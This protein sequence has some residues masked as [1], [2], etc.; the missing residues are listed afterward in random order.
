MYYL[1]IEFPFA[2]KEHLRFAFQAISK[3]HILTFDF[4]SPFTKV[5]EFAITYLRAVMSGIEVGIILAIVGVICAAPEALHSVT[6]GIMRL[7]G[8]FSQRRMR[9]RS[10]ATPSPSTGSKY[11]K[12]Q[13]TWRSSGGGM[14]DSRRTMIAPS[15]RYL[16]TMSG[17]RHM[18]MLLVLSMVIT[19]GCALFV[20]GL[21]ILIH[22][23]SPTI[24]LLGLQR[25]SS[26]LSI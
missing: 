12:E 18:L 15:I 1:P 19:W 21:L 13:H 11:V 2:I 5:R 20:L 23:T 3:S 26:R 16:N 6:H 4:S 22:Q 9:R 8:W 14:S 24:F 7:R 25:H 17:T 10:E